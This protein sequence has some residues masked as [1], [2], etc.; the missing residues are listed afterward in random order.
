MGFDPQKPFNELPLLPPKKDIETK[1]VL[2]KT[3]IVAR[4]LASLNGTKNSIPNAAILIN[5]IILQ[6]AKISSEIEN[7]ITTN[8]V[9]F[10]AIGA[11]EV[12]LDPQTKEV[13]AYRD[14]VWDG[15]S[16]LKKKGFL[17]TNL[18]VEIGNRIKNTDAGIRK[19]TGTTLKSS[20]GKVIYTPPEGEKIIRDKLANLEKYLNMDD[21]VDPLVKM[22]VQHYQ[23]EAIHPFYD[24]NG[25]SGRIL[26]I[27]YLVQAGLLELP[28]LYLSKFII[29][30]KPKY[31][32]LLLEVS[33]SEKWE[34]WILFMLD[35]IEKTAIDTSE[36][37]INIRNLLNQTIEKARSNLPKR[38]YTKE[39]I[40][41]LFV[42]PYCR[43]Q[44][45]VNAGIAERQTAASYLD[46][47]V[48][49]GILKKIKAGRENIYIN[50]KLYELLSK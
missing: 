50:V 18:F 26:C 6:E 44:D 2:K 41:L 17:T 21:D 12:G 29:E 37:I 30:N 8:D 24:G 33:K 42:M 10:K 16:M 45:V 23:F 25:R 27:L 31:H 39:L 48:K 7:V 1:A 36:S 9:L 4:A 20:T 43:N 11:N 13:L 19:T 28:I 15:F 14:A 38:A 22:A 35:G 49:I 40:E 5:T 46:E 47:C 3:A 32:G 34:Q